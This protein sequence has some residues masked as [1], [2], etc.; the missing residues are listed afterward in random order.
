MKLLLSL[1]LWINFSGTPD[2]ASIRKMYTNVTKSESNAKEFSAKLADVSNTDDKILVAYKAASILLDSK[3]EKKLKD[4]IDRFKEGAKLL[5]S[6]IKSEPNNIEIRMIRLSIQENVPGI[7]GYKKNIKE[8]KKYLTEHY[9]A[10]NTTLKEYLKDFILQ[11]KSF[12]EKE[13]QFVK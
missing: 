9:S 2:L 12:S 8:D 13:R 4:K 7:T 6:T 3:L 10:Q 11:S 1:L 5:E